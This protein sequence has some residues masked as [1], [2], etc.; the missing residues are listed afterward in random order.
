MLL[1]LL[2]LVATH[3]NELVAFN[4]VG[5]ILV[6]GGLAVIVCVSPCALPELGVVR[7]VTGQWR[8][9]ERRL[10]QVWQQL[11]TP[12]DFVDAHVLRGAALREHLA[13]D[14]ALLL[15]LPLRDLLFVVE[16]TDLR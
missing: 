6:R 12:H 13:E 15:L 14:V 8:I 11:L 1:L 16:R 9:A 7:H 4:G 2:L 10:L 5:R 3:I